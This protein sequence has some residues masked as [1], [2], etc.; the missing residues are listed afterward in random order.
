MDWYISDTHFGHERIMRLANRPFASAE[1]MD[2]AL[3][4]N[5]NERVAQEDTVYHLGDVAFGP[6]NRQRETLCSLAGRKVLIIGSHDYDP[7]FLA[8]CG[9]AEQ[10]PWLVVEVCGTPVYLTHERPPA[11]EALPEPC[12]HCLHGHDHRRRSDHPFLNIAVDLT[13]FRPLCADEIA[14]RLDFR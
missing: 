1:E 5:W 6:K 2:K 9:F 8:E 7:S 12:M 13:G 3:T 14:E 10:H 4:D 11:L